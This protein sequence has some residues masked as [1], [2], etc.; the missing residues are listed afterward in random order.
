MVMHDVANLEFCGSHL[1]NIITIMCACC[2]VGKQ[3]LSHNSSV[4]DG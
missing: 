2:A 1:Q 3:P 4:W